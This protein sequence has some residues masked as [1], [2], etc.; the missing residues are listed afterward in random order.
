MSP[1]TAGL[2][3]KMERDAKNPGVQGWQDSSAGKGACCQAGGSE[4]DPPLPYS[5]KERP[6]CSVLHTFA[7][8]EHAPQI[9]THNT[10]VFFF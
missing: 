8:H 1:G 9:N 7:E 3:D 5:V 2:E 10:S 6:S 4:F